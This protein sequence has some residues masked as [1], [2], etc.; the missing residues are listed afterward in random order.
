MA[1]LRN[2]FA[3]VELLEGGSVRVVA[4]FPTFGAAMESLGRGFALIGARDLERL[5]ARHLVA[6]D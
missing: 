6:V 4:T 1:A 5:A 3:V 2:R